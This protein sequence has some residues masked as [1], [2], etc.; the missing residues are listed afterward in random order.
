MLTIKLPMP[1][2]SQVKE[3]YIQR[4]GL[5]KDAL[6][7]LFEE[8][9]ETFKDHGLSL[10]IKYRLKSLDSLYEKVSRRV[11]E[12]S[13]ET[14]T[15]TPT[16]LLGMRVICPFLSNI[17]HV[18]GILEK[19]Y[20]VIEKDEKGADL[21]FKEFGYESLHFLIKAPDSI[22]EK[23]NLSTDTIIEIQVRTLLQDA[24]A[25]VEHQLIYKSESSPLDEP[26]RRRLA[27][28]SA[29]LNLSDI[30]FQEIRDYQTSLHNQL[31][32]RR[33]DFWNKLNSTYDSPF[34][35]EQKET[36]DRAPKVLPRNNDQKLLEGLL[37]H[38]EGEYDR[39]VAIYTDILTGEHR[40]KIRSIV[41]VHRGM[42]YFSQDKLE[43]AMEDFTSSLQEDPSNSK[44]YLYRGL[45]LV[46]MENPQRA[47]EDF[48]LALEYDPYSQDTLLERG[49]LYFQL[50]QF[51][52][53]IQDC[54]HILH[55]N[56][57]HS[58]AAELLALCEGLKR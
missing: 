28:L 43:L 44:G 41:Y 23:Y 13:E 1:S 5:Y 9:M 17:A 50:E 39:S 24:W 42:A 7:D 53:C 35:P 12:L 40:G 22:R 34:N 4:Q 16:D 54:R 36:W 38:N 20:E 32:Q 49:K 30:M 2:Y 37:A 51:D 29:N 47:L 6:K 15:Y 8:M 3:L 10:T 19:N 18:E 58:K 11:A 55:I 46:L 52:L 57:E 25:E 27:A 45:I 56:P 48:A 26:M 33:H 21:G 14:T 31:Y